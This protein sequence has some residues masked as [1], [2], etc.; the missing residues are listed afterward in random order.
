MLAVILGNLGEKYVALRL[1]QRVIYLEPDQSDAY[2]AIG[3]YMESDGDLISAIQFYK[4]CVKIDTTNM[5][6]MAA[7]GR[8]LYESARYN[9]AIEVLDVLLNKYIINEININY[10]NYSKE[11][12]NKI[13]HGLNS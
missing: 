3:F 11:L 8:V 7:L 9:D 10:Y 4:Q 2:Y 1:L 13:L 12:M 5:R 6:A